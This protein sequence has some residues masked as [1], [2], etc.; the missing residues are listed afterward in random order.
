MIR[1]CKRGEKYREEE[2]VGPTHGPRD[3]STASYD[4][5]T[6]WREKAFSPCFDQAL[7]G[8]TT[9]REYSPP[10]GP[11][12]YNIASAVDAPTSLYFFP[13]L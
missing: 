9:Q 3:A 6:T 1:R 4:D 2:E 8:P 10:L 12:T 7:S 13:V 11:D 5:Y